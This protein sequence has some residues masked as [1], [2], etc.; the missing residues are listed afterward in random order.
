MPPKALPTIPL[1][2]DGS[3]PFFRT[4]IPGLKPLKKRKENNALVAF[5]QDYI[6][7][8]TVCIFF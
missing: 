2:W 3:N 7:T 6:N 8:V 1:E 5:A 4:K